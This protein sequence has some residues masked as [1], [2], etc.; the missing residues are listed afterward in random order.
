MT[1]DTS[2]KLQPSTFNRHLLLTLLTPNFPTSQTTNDELQPFTTQSA[3]VGTCLAIQPH[4]GCV[5]QTQPPRTHQT[6]LF[7]RETSKL[8][9]FAPWIVSTIFQPPKPLSPTQKPIRE[10]TGRQLSDTCSSPSLTLETSCSPIHFSCTPR[11]CTQPMVSLVCNL[12]VPP[13]PGPPP[14]PFQADLRAG[15]PPS[16]FSPKNLETKR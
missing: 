6:Y 15:C 13:A 14:W 11:L 7:S 5:C 1:V 3:P 12:T 9:Q 8:I 4:P 10:R 16:L 2:N